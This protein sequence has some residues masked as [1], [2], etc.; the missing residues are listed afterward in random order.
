LNVLGV[1][2]RAH[3]GEQEAESRVNF[4]GPTA[5]SVLTHARVMRSIYIQVGPFAGWREFHAEWLRDEPC[6][7]TATGPGSSIP[8]AGANSLPDTGNMRFG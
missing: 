5:R 4:E 7:A 8:G 6:D 1:M 3:L 2:S